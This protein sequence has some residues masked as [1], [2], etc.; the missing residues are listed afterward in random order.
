MLL[1]IVGVMT[2]PPYLLSSMYLIKISR[3]D[4][5]EFPTDTKHR[6]WAGMTIG[7]LAFLYIIFMAYSAN[8][9]YT[10][11]SFIFYALGIPLYVWARKQH[12]KTVFTKGEWIFAIIIIAVAIY[13]VYDLIH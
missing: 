5:N 3:K 6:R 2:V 11:I 12:G 13:G 8:I 7:I 4:A 1:T 9:K 10:L